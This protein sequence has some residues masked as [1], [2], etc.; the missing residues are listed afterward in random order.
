MVQAFGIFSGGLDSILSVRLLLDQGIKPTLVTCVSPF[1]PPDQ[2]QAAAAVMGLTPVLVDVYDELLALIKNPP[3]GLGKNLNPCVDCHALMFRRAGRLLAATGEPGFLFS[4]EVLGQRPMSQN[5]RALKTVAQDSNN[6]GLVLRPLSAQ[7]LPP[8]LAE[9]RGWVKREGLL[10]LS[11][12]GRRL[13]MN[14]AEKYGFKV[15]PPAGGCLLTDVGY[16]RRLSWLLGRPQGASDPSWPPVRLAEMIKRGRLFTPEDGQWLMVGRHQ[17][18]NQA[19]ENLLK[20]GD[21]TFHLEGAPGPTVLWPSC[22]L[23]P[24]EKALEL[25][26]RLAAAYGDHG[27]RAEV[28]VLQIEHGGEVKIFQT[29]TDRPVEWEKMMV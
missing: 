20:P 28:E 4:G 29:P 18:D 12:R 26:R 7:L 11:G 22:G 10:G 9:E 15:P 19:L 3:H 5:S 24:S 6:A 21:L 14:L 2:A 23:P 25:G 8:T 27:G 13:Q 1:F 17:S 16:S